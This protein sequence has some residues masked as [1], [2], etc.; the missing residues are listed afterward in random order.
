MLLSIIAA[1][2][3]VSL[4]SFVG[5]VFFTWQSLRK[6]VHTLLLVSFAA[7]VL[8]ATSFLDILPEAL[9]ELSIGDGLRWAMIGMI[10]AFL[11]ERLLLWHHHHHEH[12]HDIHPS[13]LLVLFGDGIHNFIDGLAI[14]ASFIA[15][16]GL[17]IATTVA[18]AAHE[19]PQELA[20]YSVLLHCGMTR[21]KALLW[22]LLSAFTA[23]V[24]GLVGYYFFR[25]STGFVSITLAL[26]SGLFIYISAADLIPELHSPTSRKGWLGQTISFLLGIVVMYVV[27]TFIKE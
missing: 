21:K 13:A 27:V 5:A 12:D 20:D 26:T 6:T 16:P 1:N 14:A 7:G 24:G 23:I 8:I 19:I 18:I 10:V 3:F 17:G 9:E 2:I 11:M 4:I 22:N 15:N 25:E